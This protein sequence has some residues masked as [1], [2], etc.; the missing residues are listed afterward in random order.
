MNGV[1]ILP[2]NYI[3]HNNY[4]IY[5]LFIFEFYLSYRTPITKKGL[6]NGVLQ[7]SLVYV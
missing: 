4:P 2:I 6:E 5:I 3:L 7:V 1:L